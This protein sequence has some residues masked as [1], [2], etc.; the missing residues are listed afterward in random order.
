MA[1]T[2]WASAEPRRCRQSASDR[3]EFWRIP[4]RF[5]HFLGNMCLQF[6]SSHLMSLSDHRQS[7]QQQGPP[8]QGP[9]PVLLPPSYHP[10]TPSG[11]HS[12]P[13]LA[14]LTGGAS[15]GHHPPPP[16]NTHPPPPA[17]SHSLPALGQTVPHQ[18]PQ[19]FMSRDR[20]R[21]MQEMR[22][23]E[24]RERELQRQIEQE[25]RD[26]EARERHERERDRDHIERMHRE[27]QQQQQ[28]HP[29]QSHTGSIPIHQPVASKVPNSIHGPNGLLSNIGSGQASQA[30]NAQAGNRGG[31]NIFGI[32][33]L[34]AGN[35]SRQSSFMHQPVGPPQPQPGP[36]FIG[37]GPGPGPGPVPG[38]VPGPGPSPMPGQATLGQGQQPILNVSVLEFPFLE[39]HDGTRDIFENRTTAF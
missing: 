36:G 10:S 4:V 3:P 37:P 19:S 29:V 35:P 11:G 28:Q 22:D 34:P 27:Q 14:D 8:Q 9:A 5:A 1:G 21:D 31:S 24:R 18:S 7:M 39:S 33:A 32:P 12:L 30:S 20:D 2:R 13:T 6:S 38:P 15:S 17:P 26:R 16:Y 23:R 25:H